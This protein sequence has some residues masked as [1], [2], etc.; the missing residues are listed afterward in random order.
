MD[1]HRL[2]SELIR[3]LRQR[4]QSG[5]ISERNLARV[6]GISQPHLHNVLKGKRVLSA[7]KA[8]E[9]LHHLGLDLR[10]LVDRD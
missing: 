3:H 9:I 10:D 5:E 7:A 4:I 1:F 6:I 2:Q 8:D